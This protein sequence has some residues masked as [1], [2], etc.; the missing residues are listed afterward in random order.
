MRRLIPLKGECVMPIK[1]IVLPVAAR[2]L[3]AALAIAALTPAATSAGMEQKIDGHYVYADGKGNLVVVK[4][5][6]YKQILVGQGKLADSIEKVMGTPVRTA[7][8]GPKPT[9]IYLNAHLDQDEQY[10]QIDASVGECIGGATVIHGRSF[11]YGIPRNVTP[12]INNSC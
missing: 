12:V 2:V 8:N 9:V 1:Q 5:G 3:G 10:R 4:P 11:M 6:S 7:D